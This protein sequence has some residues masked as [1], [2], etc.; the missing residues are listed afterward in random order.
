MQVVIKKGSHIFQMESLVPSSGNLWLLLIKER[1]P[2]AAYIPLT[3][4]FVMA[5]CAMAAKAIDMHLE[6]RPLLL[7]FILAL[8][9]FFRLRLFDEIKDYETDLNVDPTPPLAHGILTLRQVKSTAFALIFFELLLASTMGF[10]A[11]IA[12]AIAIGYSL[13]MYNEFFISSWLRPHLTTYAVTH[14]LVS[15]FLGFSLGSFITHTSIFKFP[16]YYYLLGLV[17]WPLFN[18][19]EFSRKTFSPSEEKEHVESYSSLFGLW[20]AISLSLSQALIASIFAQI[21]LNGPWVFWGLLFLNLAAV[22]LYLGNSQKPSA[23]HVFRVISGLYLF[24]FLMM[25]YLQT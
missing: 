25:F 22:S 4:L 24:I 20:G 19:F 2:P 18:L 8:S 21:L 11:L 9:F 23:A 13:L 16:H 7:A 1:F 17:N 6:F 10:N 12:H 5:N 15:A 14:T 3:T